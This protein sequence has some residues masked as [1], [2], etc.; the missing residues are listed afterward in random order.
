MGGRECMRLSGS[1]WLFPRQ[2]AADGGEETQPE[3]VGA[4]VVLAPF[5]S[6]WECSG[7]QLLPTA[8]SQHL[9]EP[10]SSE[11]RSRRLG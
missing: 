3:A 10:K 11:V 9:T 5:R 6:V 2:N 7:V 1:F 4:A 8:L